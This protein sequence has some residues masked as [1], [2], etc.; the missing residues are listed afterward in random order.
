MVPAFSLYC[1]PRDPIIEKVKPLNPTNIFHS[2][3]PPYVKD[4][5]AI[6]EPG[7]TTVHHGKA[8]IDAFI[9]NHSP[10]PPPPPKARARLAAIK[11]KVEPKVVKTP[12]EVVKSVPVEKPPA[13]VVPAPE[14]KKEPVDKIVAIPRPSSVPV[15]EPVKQVKKRKPRV[16]KAKATVSE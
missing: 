4:V 16:S 2:D 1:L 12:A 5:P 10:P 7:S 8:A 6:F 14:T 3:F 11:T 13:E 15:P 9:A